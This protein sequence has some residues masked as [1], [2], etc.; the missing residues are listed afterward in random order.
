VQ[1]L[2][3]AGNAAQVDNSDFA[4]GLQADASYEL[5]DHHT[6][7]AGMLATY[8]LERL[9]TTSAVFPSS[10]QFT[11]AQP[12]RSYPCSAAR[13]PCPATRRNRQPLRFTIIA[14][15]GNSGLTAGIYLQDE[16]QL[17]DHL[18]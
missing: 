13:R 6:L 1:D 3:L 15:G 4:N 9:D 14:N 12:P 17:T 18:T 2:L 5:G 10:S 8:D 16:W 7:R 11:P